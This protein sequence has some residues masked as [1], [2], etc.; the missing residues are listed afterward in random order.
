MLLIQTL[1]FHNPAF[2]HIKQSLLP[3]ET[4]NSPPHINRLNRIILPLLI[5]MD[6]QMFGILFVLSSIF[7]ASCILLVYLFVH[8]YR[9]QFLPTLPSVESTQ[10]VVE[11]TTM[12][13][14][15]EA[16]QGL[17]ESVIYKCYSCLIEED[18]LPKLPGASS[19]EPTLSSERMVVIDIPATTSA[20]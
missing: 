8:T 9:R 15:D 2:I 5:N 6:N 7:A 17:D 11:S 20:L 4:T 3:S 16:A 13:E 14:E 10:Y 1:K 19:S 18:Y 12:E